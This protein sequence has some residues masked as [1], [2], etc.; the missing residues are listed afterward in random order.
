M[1]SV[2]E[3]AE[4]LKVTRSWIWFLIQSKRLKAKKVG[5]TYIIEDQDVINY[6]KVR[7]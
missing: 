7:R 6:L 5:N 3:V 4:Q 1:K 2:T